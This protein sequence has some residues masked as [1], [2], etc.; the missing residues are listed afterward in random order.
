M[1]YIHIQLEFHQA[2]TKLSITELP[3]LYAT[4]HSQE[5]KGKRGKERGKCLGGTMSMVFLYSTRG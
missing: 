1:L 3:I 4:G 5:R 2:Y